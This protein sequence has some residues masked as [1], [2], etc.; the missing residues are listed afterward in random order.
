M[1]GLI[2]GIQRRTHAFEAARQMAASSLRGEMDS[3][4]DL[5]L[6]PA[7]GQYNDADSDAS[8]DETMPI[9]S[10]STGSTTSAEPSHPHSQKKKRSKAVY[11]P[12]AR[13]LLTQGEVL[14]LATALPRGLEHEWMLKVV[15]EGKR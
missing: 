7:V 13:D 10:T 4:G 15:P 11:K 2:F 8:G 9:A 14:N 3:M 5:S 1:L 6:G 12:W